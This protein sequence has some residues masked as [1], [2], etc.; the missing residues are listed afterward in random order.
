[1]RIKDAGGMAKRVDSN[2]SDL[3]IL[4][5][6]MPGHHKMSPKT[7]CLHGLYK[8]QINLKNTCNHSKHLIV[9]TDMFISQI[10]PILTYLVSGL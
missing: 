8:Q 1:M 5:T 6:F 7:F 3:P 10:D 9:K 4:K 2:Q